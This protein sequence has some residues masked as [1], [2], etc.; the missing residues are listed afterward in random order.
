M[1]QFVPIG[2]DNMSPAAGGAGCH[3]RTMTESTDEARFNDEFC[4]RVQRLRAEREWTQAQMATALGVPLE[5]YKKYETRS[6]LPAYLVPRFAQI[7][8]REI[9]YVLTG[10]VETSTR[11]VRNL[12]RTGTDG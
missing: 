7:V 6:P 10:K 8:D 1:G 3:N 5:R 2:K 12:V 9:S 4:A 11:R